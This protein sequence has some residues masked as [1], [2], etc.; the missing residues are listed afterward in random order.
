MHDRADKKG[1]NL[2]TVYQEIHALAAQQA[3]RAEQ[4]KAK[5]ANLAAEKAK[6]REKNTQKKKKE[7]E[8]Q[9]AR[10]PPP[11]AMVPRPSRPAPGS[12]PR[13]RSLPVRVARHR[14]RLAKTTTIRQERPY[15]QRRP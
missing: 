3:E 2:E 15:L 12:P 1:S 5:A 11:S 10:V 13:L 8:K 7:K 6:K 9:G 4:A 14:R